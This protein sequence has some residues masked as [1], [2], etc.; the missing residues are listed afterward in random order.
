[1]VV[2]V[3]KKRAS[4]KLNHYQPFHELFA[5]WG[6]RSELKNLRS[7]ELLAYWTY[8]GRSSVCGL[9]LNELLLYLLEK[10]LPM[11]ELYSAYRSALDGLQSDQSL[12]VPLRASEKHLLD[13][14]GY[15]PSLSYDAITGEEL[16]LDREGMVLFLSLSRRKP[17]ET[18]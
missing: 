5:V 12:H 4:T 16:D 10:D 15:F 18:S 13:D 14:L 3:A 17:Q 8:F 1:M 9:Y 2:R 11:P 7:A 6:G